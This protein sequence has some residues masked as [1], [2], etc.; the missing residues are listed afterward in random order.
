ME[1]TQYSSLLLLLFLRIIF[2]SVIKKIIKVF[3]LT[4]WKM[5]RCC[6]LKNIILNVNMLIVDAKLNSKKTSC[7]IE[8]KH[9]HQ[10]K[11]VRKVNM[12]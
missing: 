8:N 5:C 1:V 11:L 7:Q 3:L 2:T 12:Y 4:I 9:T 6:Y 10:K